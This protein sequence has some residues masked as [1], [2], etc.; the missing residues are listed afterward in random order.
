MTLCKVIMTDG[1][2]KS[3]IVNRAGLCFNY[4]GLDIVDLG[5]FFGKVTNNKEIPSLA[6]WSILCR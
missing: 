5:F 6:K 2:K 1:P 3:S 4:E